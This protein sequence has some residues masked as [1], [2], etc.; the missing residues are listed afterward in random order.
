[1][2][3]AT[4]QLHHGLT[5]N[6]YP[7]TLVPDA[8]G[9]PQFWQTF[10]DQLFDQMPFRDLFDA[11]EVDVYHMDCP[12]QAELVA[13]KQMCLKDL[14]ADQAGYQRGA[15]LYS[16]KEIGIAVYP[17]NYTDTY[18]GPSRAITE[19]N[20]LGAKGVLS[21]E[22][23]HYYFDQSRYCYN[24]DDISRLTTQQINALAPKQADNI[25]E[26]MAEHY[27]AICGIDS[28][29]NTYS[30]GKTAVHP[31]EFKALVRTLYWLN[32]NFRGAW[33][34]NVT[35][36]PEGVQFCVWIGFGWEWRFV[37]ASNWQHY[38]Y[39]SSGW[40]TI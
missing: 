33:I 7:G 6:R 21:H 8:V 16:Q 39:T 14:Y 18:V 32:G 9:T 3:N 25:H 40:Q 5:L 10:L 36:K 4:N 22:F 17:T 38:K 11:L 15:G 26:N 19:A 34:S 28:D 23:G 30:D 2:P 37:M 35:P 29:R 27:R 31:P 20:R 12:E 13:K 24:T 1:M